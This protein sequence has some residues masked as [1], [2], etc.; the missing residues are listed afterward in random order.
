VGVKAPAWLLPPKPK[1]LLIL[2]SLLLGLVGGDTVYRW[3]RPTHTHT[4]QH[5]TIRS[6]AMKP[7]TDEVGVKLELLRTAYV[8]LFNNLPETAEPHAPLKVK[9]F[10]DRNEFR[11]C[12][13]GIGWAEAFY[14]PPFCH[15]YFSAEEIN[16]YHWMLH[17]AV[18]QLNHEVARFQLAQWADEGLSEYL[19]TS[20]IRDDRLLVG[21]VD[22]NTYPVWWLDELPLTGDLEKDLKD[23]TVIPLRSILTGEGGPSVNEKFNL[24]YLHWWSLVHLLYEGQQGKYREGVLPLLHAGA[25]LESFE[26]HIGPVE[27]VQDEWYQ[28]LQGLQ[29]DLFLVGSTPTNHSSPR[30][31]KSSSSRPR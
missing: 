1:R 21:Q 8:E 14:R 16:P 27:R 18:H 5:Y 31:I 24:Y 10:K 15:A 12:N 28:H 20:L 19:S 3:W 23:G 30:S 6:S 22:R 7:Q 2:F 13:R 17:E 26:Q 29:W 9:L 11:R 4:T 25:T